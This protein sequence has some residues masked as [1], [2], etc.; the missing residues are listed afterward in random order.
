MMAQFVL[1]MEKLYHII[2]TAPIL[3]M[4]RAYGLLACIFENY[5]TKALEYFFLN[6]NF[7]KIKFGNTVNNKD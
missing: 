6:R 2:G 7:Y 5:F 1:K 4:A 3:E